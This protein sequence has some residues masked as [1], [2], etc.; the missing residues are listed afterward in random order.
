MMDCRIFLEGFLGSFCMQ[1]SL[2]E[3]KF[4]QCS[5]SVWSVAL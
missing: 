5:K 4:N 2:N 3:G 1:S